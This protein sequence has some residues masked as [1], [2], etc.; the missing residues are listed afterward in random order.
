MTLIAFLT[1]LWYDVAK[2]L[3]MEIQ[4]AVSSLTVG[5]NKMKELQKLLEDLL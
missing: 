5:H 1:W 3:V 4:Y 2:Y